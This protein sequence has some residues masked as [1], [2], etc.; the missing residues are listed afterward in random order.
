MVASSD[1]ITKANQI[2]GLGAKEVSS[3]R[4]R[5]LLSSITI[6]VNFT[7]TLDLTALGYDSSDATTVME[8]FG[9]DLLASLNSTAN[10]SFASIFESTA[11][12]EGLD[13]YD[14]VPDVALSEATLSTI[15]DSV[16]VTV[17]TPTPTSLPTP[18]PSAT[19][20]PS[21]L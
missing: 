14:F 13:T 18:I 12:S 2:T 10:T 15:G 3:R 17:H 4:R 20:S 6:D 1:W 16:I 5:S 19:M 11:S 8:S 9:T 21:A 7:V